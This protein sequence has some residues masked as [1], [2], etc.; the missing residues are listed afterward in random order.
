MNEYSVFKIPSENLKSS[1]V[2]NIL[3]QDSLPA[4]LIEYFMKIIHDHSRNA[5]KDNL[6]P[7]RYGAQLHHEELILLLHYTNSI[8]KQCL[9][10]MDIDG[11]TE[12]LNVSMVILNALF[13]Q[14]GMLPIV[15]EQS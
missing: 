11:L 15:Y 1:P 6:Q 8:M 10:S 3:Q 2:I 13:Q 5:T 4:E 14:T 12:N 9:Y 7:C